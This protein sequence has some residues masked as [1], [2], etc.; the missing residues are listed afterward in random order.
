MKEKEVSSW[1]NWMSNKCHSLRQKQPGSTLKA[2]D[3]VVWLYSKPAEWVS[4]FHFFFQIKNPRLC[5]QLSFSN[6]GFVGRIF[7]S[8]LAPSLPLKIS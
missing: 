7:Q 3:T 1:A 5:Y 4:L 2:V 8:N 6:P